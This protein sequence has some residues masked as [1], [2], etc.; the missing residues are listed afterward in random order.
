MCPVVQDFDDNLRCDLV[1][2]I[3]KR[4]TQNNL[5]KFASPT[6]LKLP[7]HSQPA[8]LFYSGKARELLFYSSSCPAPNLSMLS[9]VKL[10]L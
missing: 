5:K 4:K 2:K 3:G 1:C 9:T 6:P 8:C 7:N 10:I